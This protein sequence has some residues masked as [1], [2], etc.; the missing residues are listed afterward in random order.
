MVMCL[1]PE[2][3]GKYR[4]KLTWHFKKGALIMFFSKTKSLN[5]SR[6]TLQQSYKAL[7]ESKYLSTEI[8]KEWKEKLLTLQAAID[9]N[10][11]KAASEKAIELESF[12]KKHQK[13]S[14]I[15]KT[16]EAFF[17]LLT[18]LIVA[19]I[20]RSMWFE[21]YEIPTGSMRPTFKEQDHL[22][23]SKTQFGINIPLETAHFYFDP[24]LVQRT[25][26]IVFSGDKLPLNDTDTTFLGIFPY[27]KRY[28][29][30]MIGKPEDILY[31]YGGKIFA[32]D[33]QN[34]PIDEF[35]TAPWMA[36]LEHIPFIQF[37]DSIQRGKNGNSYIISFFNR[38][39]ARVTQNSNGTLFGEIFDG[40]NW[41]PDQLE[42]SLKEQKTPKTLSDFFGIKNFA[43]AEIIDPNEL[44]NL[45]LKAESTPLYLLLY[46]HPNVDYSKG[47]NFSSRLPKTFQTVLTLSEAN[48]STLWDNLYTARFVVKN[49]K[50][51]RYSHEQKNPSKNSPTLEIP[52][53]T[54]EFYYGKAY[55][56]LFGGYQKELPKDHPIYERTIDRLKIF[57][58]LGIGWDLAY[59]QGQ[60]HLLPN[61]Y[62][63]FRDGDLYVMGGPLLKKGDD[64]LSAFVENEKQKQSNLKSDNFYIPF[65]DE[66]RPKS[67]TINQFGIKVPQ[68]EYLVLGD[69]HAMSG[70]SRFFGMV[71]E[72]NLQGVP[73]IIL[74]PPGDRLGHPEQKPYPIFVTPR[75][76][77]W[78]M[79]GT[80]A[81]ICYLVY[82]YKLRRRIT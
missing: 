8:L 19:I 59:A 34:R 40:K 10:D 17:A 77:I 52:D 4:N 55:E 39:L 58:N 43:I 35:L 28:V 47:V 27:K 66:G 71:P 76:I 12:T 11:I 1:A 79:A 2:V 13:K 23:V 24:N 15:K 74:W 31:F 67:D 51:T 57:F 54:Y 61:R 20:I 16:F 3:E 9:N 63:Y 26:T 69:N 41:I 75:L 42:E 70:D 32:N 18:A 65:I 29:K 82:S 49:G 22:T 5:K 46:H 53:G 30:R 48:I 68:K 33:F 60:N 7:N 56:I 14:H 73:D 6:H 80:I 81:L 64:H 62:A 21:L 38:P 50:A 25:S 78:A 45:G 36:P 44:K 72:N 37:N